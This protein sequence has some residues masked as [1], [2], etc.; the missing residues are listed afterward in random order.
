MNSSSFYGGDELY[1]YIYFFNAVCKFCNCFVFPC[2]FG[3][4]LID[5]FPSNSIKIVFGWLG[6]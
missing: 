3:S 2:Y 5:I 4:Q 6:F 1:I